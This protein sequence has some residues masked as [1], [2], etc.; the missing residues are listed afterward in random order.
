[1]IIS[2]KWLASSILAISLLGSTPVWAFSGSLSKDSLKNSD[3]RIMMDV[4]TY[5]GLGDDGSNNGSRRYATFRNPT[6]LLLKPDGT[7]I[8]SDTRNHLLRSIAGEK[9]DTLA[10]LIVWK[11]HKGFPIGSRLD[12]K[13][14]R[15]LFQEPMGLASD[16]AGSIYVADAGNHAIRKIDASGHVTTLAGNGLIGN[17]DGNGDEAAFNHP[18]GVAVASDGTV[19]VADTLNHVIRSISPAGRTTTLTAS[20][21]RLAEVTPG[22]VVRSGD[23]KDGAISEAKFNEPT[24]LALDGKGNLYISDAG[25]QRIRYMDFGSGTVTTVAG[26]GQEASG[27]LYSNTGLYVRG[28][29]AD[30]EARTARFN[31]PQGIALTQEGGLII[32]DS[33][34]RSIRY[35]L[36]GQV[37]TLAGNA[38]RLSGEADGVEQAAEFQKPMGVA[39]SMDGSIYVS[40]AFNNKIRCLSLYRLPSELPRN[41][42]VKVV[43]GSQVISFE[44]Q[45]EIANGRTMVPVRAIAEALGYKVGYR[46]EDRSVQLTKGEVTIEL[47]IDKTGINKFRTQQQVVMKATDAAPYM[48]ENVTYVPVRFFAEEIGLDV[49]WDESTSTAILRPKTNVEQS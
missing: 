42:H 43:V 46:D 16:A 2:A 22:Q 1:M 35:L 6:G 32:A 31:F 4:S 34:N 25:N 5:A 38:K 3:G 8:V 21:T 36:D 41:N 18:Q 23:Y 10:G 9:V 20:S 28:D 17:K 40:D 29:Y 30:G 44:A 49:Q 13:A 14:D 27:V 12:G 19:Y 45:P 15:S 26:G 37:T 48:K 33:M 39:I 24:G 47:Y 7:L 11:D